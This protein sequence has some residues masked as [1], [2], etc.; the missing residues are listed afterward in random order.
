MRVVILALV[1][2]TL[3]LSGLLPIAGREP[4]DANPEHPGRH[5]L[6][7]PIAEGSPF[8]HGFL[9]PR[10]TADPPPITVTP[11]SPRKQLTHSEPDEDADCSLM[12][13]PQQC[14]PSGHKSGGRRGEWPISVRLASEVA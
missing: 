1:S 13:V 7:R 11:C 12:S 4:D 10:H 2:R 6:F 3:R 14:I 8:A 9:I 5:D